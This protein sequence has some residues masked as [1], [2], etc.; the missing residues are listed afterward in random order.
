[1]GAGHTA[2]RR[3]QERGRRRMEQVLDVAAAVFA[4]VGY[5]RATTNAIAARAGMSPGSLY[6]FFANK[7]VI[8][9]ALV[10]RYA[11]QLRATHHAAFDPGTVDLTLQVSEGPE[12]FVERIDITGNTRTADRVIRRELGLVE[13]ERLSLRKL[14]RAQQRLRNLGYFESVAVST[15]T[16]CG[17]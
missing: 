5:D 3:R 15:V 17:A 7:E 9:E 10:R 14:E 16:D 6:Q 13:G 1:M 12:T 8:A 11:Q 4:E 2:P